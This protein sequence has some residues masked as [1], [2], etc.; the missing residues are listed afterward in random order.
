MRRVRGVQN[1]GARVGDVRGDR[2]D[3]EARHETFGGFAPALHAKGD[4][5]ARS[6]RHILLRE[7]VVFVA[8]EA[9][10]V[11]PRDLVVRFE[12]FRHRLAVFAVTLHAQVQRFEPEIEEERVLRR[13]GGTEIAHELRDAFGDERPALAELFGV[14]DS[15]I[16]FVGRRESRILILVSEPVEIARIDD[17]AADLR[18]VPVHIFRRGVRDDIDAELEGTA[19]DGGREGVV[20]DEGNAVLVGDFGEEFEVEDIERGVG[21][22][23]AEHRASIRLERG[24]EFVFGRVGTHE[25]EVDSHPLHRDGEEVVRPPVDRG[26]RD[27]VIPCGAE[28]EDGEEVRGLSGGGKHPRSTAFEGGDLRGDDIARRVL[29]TSVEVPGGFE[30][31]ELAH[32]GARLIAERRALNDRNLTRLAVF[33]TISR[34]NAF[35]TK[36]LHESALHK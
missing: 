35:C 33:R 32:R 25:G 8:L 27:D 18:P 20:D 1:A 26:G 14:D 30:V 4:D 29:Q 16:A 7:R 21:D 11:H 28:V 24:V 6:V 5:P 23:F 10:I 17:R 22:R 31:E 3:L 34:L 13:G 2:R 36:L 15:V 12:E 9:G 19:V